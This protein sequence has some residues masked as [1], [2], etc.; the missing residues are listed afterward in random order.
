MMVLLNILIIDSKG[1]L[2]FIFVCK[3]KAH[4]GNHA[5]KMSICKIVDYT[6]PWSSIESATLMKPPM[7]A[8]FT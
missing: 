1:F 7:F 2:K 3:K 6:R 4:G 8:P 5:L